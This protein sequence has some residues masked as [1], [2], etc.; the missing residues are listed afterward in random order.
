[1]ASGDG[2]AVYDA[3]CQPDGDDAEEDAAHGLTDRLVLPGH[4][5]HHHHPRLLLLKTLTPPHA[6]HA[7]LEVGIVRDAERPAQLEG[8]PEGPGRPDRFG[9][10]THQADAGGRNA[11]T[12]EEVAEL[13][14]I[15][16]ATAHREQRLAQAWLAQPVE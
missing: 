1:M 4:H 12:L 8:D 10:L 13:L 3:P 16:V 11:L 5:L 2:D 7:A 6:Q 9:V 14:E 15:S